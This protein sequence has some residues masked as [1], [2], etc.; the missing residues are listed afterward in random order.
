[1]CNDDFN[2]AVVFA[3]WGAM[4]DTQSGP[5][6]PETANDDH[7]ARFLKSLIAVCKDNR[8]V[9]PGLPEMM[10]RCLERLN[11]KMAEA[12]H[13]EENRYEIMHGYK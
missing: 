6:E 3:N 1:M 5:R 13:A 10:E 8:D 2:K 9:L 11:P 7:Q 4:T 12:Q